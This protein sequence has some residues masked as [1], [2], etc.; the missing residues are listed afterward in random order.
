MSGRLLSVV[1][2]LEA[3]RLFI[4]RI[5]GEM[6]EAPFRAQRKRLCGKTDEAVVANI[7]KINL[8]RR[9]DITNRTYAISGEKE[10]T[11]T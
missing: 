4:D 10:E 11:K 1:I 2:C 8:Q 6:D 5:I 3:F 7:P 9:V